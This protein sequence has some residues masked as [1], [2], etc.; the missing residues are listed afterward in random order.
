MIEN[1]PYM[2]GALL[3][4]YAVGGHLPEGIDP[5]GFYPVTTVLEDLGRDVARH[6]RV[7]VM[8][9]S[10]AVY[11]RIPGPVYDSLPRGQYLVE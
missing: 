4:E 3:A 2:R 7:Q 5:N 11:C 9:G 1:I 6:L 8:Q 10:R